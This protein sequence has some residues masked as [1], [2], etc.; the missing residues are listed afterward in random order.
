M[1]S[2]RALPRSIA[3]PVSVPAILWLAA[4][5]APPLAHAQAACSSD[6]Q[7]A[8]VALME[9]FINADCAECW[10]ASGT[11]QPPRG[12][13]A[14]DWIV[15]GRQGEDAPLSAAATRDASARLQARGLEPPPTTSVRM[16]SAGPA[17]PLRLRVAHGPALNSYVGASIAVRQTGRLQKPVAAWLALVET[18][19]AGVEGSP[20]ERNLVRNVLSPA[21]DG[22]EA[23]SKLQNGQRIESR[24]M[25][26]PAGASPERLR[27]VGWVEDMQGRISVI[28]Q[29]RCTPS[30]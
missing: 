8:P 18:I 11:P 28:A 24:V 21:W 26:I 12:V 5:A 9:R 14:L 30:P 16:T 23:L 27:V 3:L 6:G 10:S 1:K 17:S 7:R 20:V 19:P 2:L 13:L 22:L 29:S 4:L 15:P 25:G